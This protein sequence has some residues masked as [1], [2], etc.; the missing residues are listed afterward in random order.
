[1]TN[2]APIIYNAK[3]NVSAGK[4]PRASFVDITER[5]LRVRCSIFLSAW[6]K[7]SKG[8]PIN[9]LARGALFGRGRAFAVASGNSSYRACGQSIYTI[10]S[11]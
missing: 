11:T 3:R 10:L 8:M 4:L 6:S 5:S 9:S 7:R 2:M 1:M